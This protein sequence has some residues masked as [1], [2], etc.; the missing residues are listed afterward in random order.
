M[1]FELMEAALATLFNVV[2]GSIG[3]AFLKM[4]LTRKPE[5]KR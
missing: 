1:S 5:K 4:H 3:A 2:L